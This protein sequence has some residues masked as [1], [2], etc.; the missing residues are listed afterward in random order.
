MIT[1]KVAIVFAAGKGTRLAPITHETPKPLIE[2]GGRTLLDWNLQNIA[3]HVDCI[4]LVVGWLGDKIRDTIGTQFM[5]TPVLYAEQTELRG[6]LDAF[7]V[8]LSVLDDSDLVKDFLVLNSDDIHA[9]ETYQDF[10]RQIQEFPET[11]KISA[12]VVNNREV[13]KSF[14]VFKVGPDNQMLSMVEKPQEFVSNLVNTAI[15]YFP[16]LILDYMPEPDLSL[17]EEYL[18]EHLLNV[19]AKEHEVIIVPSHGYWLPVNS[20]EQLEVARK[21]IEKDD[22]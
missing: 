14:G 12:Q 5:N 13:L 18:T 9:P 11:A 16:N 3:G 19:Y 20:L 1:N 15:Y 2:V 22:K 8:G 7:R 21:F 10:F 17:K 6:T 4:V